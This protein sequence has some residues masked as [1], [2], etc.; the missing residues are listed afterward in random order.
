[1]EDA[2]GRDDGGLG[3]PNLNAAVPHCL[4]V[5]WPLLYKGDVESRVDEVSTNPCA[6]SAGSEES[7]LE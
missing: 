6:L 7:N 3:H 1:M 4:H 2:H 5:R